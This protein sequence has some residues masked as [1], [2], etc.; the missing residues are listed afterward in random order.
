MASLTSIV[1]GL[2][3]P[4]ALR[5]PKAT[6]QPVVLQRNGLIYGVDLNTQQV[7]QIGGAPGLSIS[8]DVNDIG[9]TAYVVGSRLGVWQV[10]LNNAAPTLPIA[11]R[12]PARAAHIQNNANTLYVAEN[13]SPARVFSIALTALAVSRFARGVQ[14]ANALLLE[15]ASGVLLA[16]EASGR[17][18]RLKPGSPPSA[19]IS[20][21]GV[22]LDLAW[23]DASETQLLVADS[24]GGRILQF[25]INQPANPP[26]VLFDGIT[27]LWGV[28]VLDAN[29]LII[30]AGDGV[31]LGDLQPVVV[32]DPVTF[33]MPADPL[34]VSAWAK[35]PVIIN[36]ASINFDDL[37]FEIEPA[38]SAAQVSLSRDNSFDPANPDIMLTAGWMVGSHKL[39]AIDAPSNTIVGVGQFEVTDTWLNFNEGPSLAVLGSIEAGPNGGT[40]G[41]GDFTQ[42]QNQNVVPA[43]GTRTVAV[44]LVDTADARYPTGAA[45]TTIMN[46]FRDEM[47]NGVMVGGQLR[48][49]ANYFRQASNKAFNINLVDVVGPIS[50]PGNWGTYMD[51]RDPNASFEQTIVAQIVQLNE[52]ARRLG[53]PEFLDLSDMDSLIVVIRTVPANG[54]TPA[55]SVWPQANFGS[56][57]H[58]IGWM[59]FPGTAPLP[60]FRGIACVF[61]PDDWTGSTG[62]WGRRWH[63]TV[64][65]ELGHNLQLN[66]QY[67]KQGTHDPSV[68]AR[69]ADANPAQS[70]EL[71]SWEEDMP[72]PS[73]AHRLMLGW[74][75]SSQIK[76]FNFGVFGQVD[77]TITLHAASAGAPPPGRFA[78]VEVRIA[79]GRNYYFEYRPNTGGQVVDTNPPAAVTVFGSDVT[80]RGSTP[81]N[82]PEILRLRDDSDMDRGEFQTGDDYEE[83][84]TTSPQFPNDFIVNVVST[85]ADSATIRVRYGLDQEPDPALMPWSASTNW[86][87]PDIEVIN[88]RSLADPAF[89]NI[90]WEGHDNTVLARV[91]NRGQIPAQGVVVRFG[92]KD[93]TFAGGAETSLGSQ[94]LDVN[95]GATVTFAAP[96]VWRPPQLKFSVPWLPA[97]QYPQHACLVAR[98]D[99]FINGNV[100]EVTPDNNEAQSN[101]TWIAT[102][103][104]SPSTRQATVLMA[105]NPFDVGA[106]VSFEISQPNPL[107]RVY[108]SHRWVYLEPGEQKPILVMTESLFGDPR[109][110]DYTEQLWNREERVMTTVRLS[111]LGDTGEAC[112]PAVLG[113]ASILAIAGRM[114]EFEYFHANAD[115]AEGRVISV[116]TREGVNGRVLVSIRPVK[117]EDDR[118][119]IVREAFA[120]D[121]HFI[122][123]I[124]AQP[125]TIIQGHYLGNA[126]FAPCDSEEI[127]I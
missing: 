83:V 72:L 107:F 93:F 45:L 47:V 105:D 13:R 29:R 88:G 123:E 38:E 118:E 111:A 23:R 103:T 37:V 22:P 90:P 74:L 11:P 92:A 89:R 115:V 8:F 95:N 53:T 16:A 6:Q 15:S 55:Q 28:K 54:M 112:A 127:A 27:D 42:P 4:I 46:G 122:I 126:Q 59:P 20:G 117:E 12:L 113:G 106:I 109:F 49:V 9:T 25:D 121:G 40:W 30:G 58:L 61:M 1:S 96:N 62:A 87:S 2:K 94:T 5:L 119:E 100:V 43:L 50:L 52:N 65:H 70:W 10:G 84:D 86:Q 124:G 79:D 81:A 91:T 110:A 39:V 67:F 48:S 41:G 120:Q 21:F 32:A 69:I 24:A 35:V 85:T 7:T 63:D 116:D 77:Q 33:D 34:F 56:K 60:R 82:R 31:W 66:D 104:A 75:N 57:T 80:S 101:Y 3:R 18:S 73:A 14:G 125:E 36:D 26:Q 78:A 99:P 68:E 64:A 108:L 97:L 71:M 19:M 114:T 98:I 51:G 102:S 44:I 76:L 17:I